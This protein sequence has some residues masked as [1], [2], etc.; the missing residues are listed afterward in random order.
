MVGRSRCE[1]VR[2][3]LGLARHAGARRGARRRQ[4]SA[5]SEHASAA[6]ELRIVAAVGLLGAA[7]L[8]AAEHRRRRTAHGRSPAPPT[9]Q[10][11]LDRGHRR[12]GGFRAGARG[13]RARRMAYR[14]G[15]G[16]PPPRRGGGGPQAGH[17]ADGR[18]SPRMPL[19]SPSLLRTYGLRSA[20]IFVVMIV[21][22]GAGTFMLHEAA[23]ARVVINSR[24]SAGP[25][26]DDLRVARHAGRHRVAPNGDVYFADSQQRRGVAS[27]SGGSPWR[28]PA[29]AR[30]RRSAGNQG[31]V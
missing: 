5:P 19:V 2:R 16:D 11:L 7:L 6:D 12:R 22:V 15:D 24:R 28:S 30:A 21:A 27:G 26:P 10:S 3:P 20:L 13:G 31:D 29:G 14:A 4:E 17:G 9:G 1:R 25:Q 8:V 23:T 18:R